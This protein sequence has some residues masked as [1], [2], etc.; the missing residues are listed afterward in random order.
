MLRPMPRL[1][2]FLTSRSREDDPQEAPLW[3]HLDRC[4]LGFRTPM[5]ELIAAHGAHPIGWTPDLD[6]CMPPCAKPLFA[7]LD[8][9]PSFRFDAATDL[10]QPP[11]LFH[12]A[13]RASPDHRV[14]YARAIKALCDLF[15][16]GEYSATQRSSGR[17]W[18]F[19]RAWL[20]CEVHPPELQ[21]NTP[22]LR[23]EMFP[24][25]RVEA[26]ISFAPAWG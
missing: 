14:N 15:G 8:H 16:E 17:E 22:N 21:P 9:P 11:A 12:A 13:L 6:I 3:A 19:G 1:P 26:A 25:S 5:A 10:S 20:R 7:G 18:R 4:G 24:K 2:R 23:H